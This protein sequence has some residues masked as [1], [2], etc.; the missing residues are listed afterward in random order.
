MNDM[1]RRKRWQI[2]SLA[3]AG[4]PLL[5]DSFDLKSDAQRLID[6]MT[7]TYYQLHKELLLRKPRFALVDGKEDTM[8]GMKQHE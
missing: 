5:V 3:D 6:R 1:P 7:E 8:E 4:N 2:Y